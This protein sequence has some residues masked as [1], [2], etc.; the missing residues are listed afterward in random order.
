MEVFRAVRIIRANGYYSSKTN[1]SDIL[2]GRLNSRGRLDDNLDAS[3][4]G[5]ILI[6]SMRDT[7]PKQSHTILVPVQYHGS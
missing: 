7:K 4:I 6:G 3:K 5:I 1:P 2:F